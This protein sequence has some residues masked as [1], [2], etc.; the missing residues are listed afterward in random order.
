M[1]RRRQRGIGDLDVEHGEERTDQPVAD[2]NPGARLGRLSAA[3]LDASVTT[4]LILSDGRKVF[5]PHKLP[6]LPYCIRHQSKIGQLQ[7]VSERL[8]YRPKDWIDD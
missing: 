5:G 2:G 8:G 6:V 4:S 3:A 1:S 7:P